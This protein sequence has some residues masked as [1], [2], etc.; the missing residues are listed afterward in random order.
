MWKKNGMV[1]KPVKDVSHLAIIFLL[2]TTFQ[3]MLTPWWLYNIL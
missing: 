2:K 1:S 3:R